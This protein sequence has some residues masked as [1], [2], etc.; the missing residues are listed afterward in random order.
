MSTTALARRLARRTAAAVGR[1]ARSSGTAA[2]A[3]GCPF[4]RAGV[5]ALEPTAHR[6]AGAESWSG[7]QE[8]AVA[9]K[10]SHARKP[11]A[12]LPRPQGLPV[13]GTALDVLRAGG[14]PKIHE[15]CDRRHR[16]LGPIYRETLGSVDAVFVADSALIQKVYTNEG[17]FPMHMV[18]EPW[19][20]YN[21]VKGIQRGLFFMDGPEWIDRRRSLNNVFLKTKTVTDNVPVFNDVIT[22]LLNRWQEARND[23][24]ILENVERELYNWSIESLGAMIFGRRLGCIAHSSSMDNVHEF[25]HCV[26]QIFNESAK[27]SMFSPRLAYRLRLPVWRRFVRA[28]GRALELARDYVEENVKAI[29]KDPSSTAQHNQGILSQLLLNEKISEDELVRIV[30]DLFLAA[31]DTTSHATQWALYLLAKHPEQQERLLDSVRSVVPAGQS[32]SEESLARLP[33]VKAVIR[34]ALRLYPVAPFLTRIL[35]EDIVLDGYHIPAGK[36]ILMSL[37]TTGRDPQHFSDPHTFRP[38]RWLR[39]QDRAGQVNSWACLPFGLGVRSCIGRRVAEVQMQFLI[40]RTVQRFQLA[41]S[42]DRDVQIKMRLITTPEE[43]I[44]L[45]MTPR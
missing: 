16:E 44:S 1:R 7:A 38:E 35:S 6:S 27:M 41:P 3:A 4:H 37:Y 23:E 17:K 2:A 5:A 14:A 29:A 30:T 9:K 40:A 43:P 11:F 31:A 21:E 42:T 10:S 25:V 12:S 22:D 34:E 36:L 15:Y 24:G 33:Y 28:A 8:F 39:D 32:I 18:P 19:L 13:L 26:Q 45:R 20:I